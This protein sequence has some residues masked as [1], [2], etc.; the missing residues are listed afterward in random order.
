M[1]RRSTLFVAML[2]A[3]SCGLGSA[4]ESTKAKGTSVGDLGGKVIAITL[5]SDAEDLV[6]LSGVSE[7]IIA[8]KRFLC[9][10]GVNDGDTPDWRNDAAVY[11]PLEDVQQIVA[12]A[13]LNAYKKNLNAR[14]ERSEGK[15]ASLRTRR[16][17]RT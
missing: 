14:Q 4:Q 16:S 2:A 8:G 15:A 13:D 17:Q 9:G 10:N 12:F 6:L 1:N 5:V 11:I 3:L 7:T